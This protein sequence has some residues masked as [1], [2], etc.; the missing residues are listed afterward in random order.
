[1]SLATLTPD[2]VS[3][4]LR[5]HALVQRATRDGIAGRRLAEAER[6]A[7]MAFL[8]STGID[9][10]HEVWLSIEECAASADRP[11]DL[12][13]FSERCETCRGDVPQVVGCATCLGRGRG[14]QNV[15]LMVR[16]PAGLEDE[17]RI[18]LTGMGE[19]GNYGARRGDLYLDIHQLPHERFQREG[20][21]VRSAQTVDASL[22]A[23]G[24]IV[25]VDT[26]TG[27]VRARIPPGTEPGSTLRLRGYGMPWLRG[28]GHGDFYVR[29]L[30]S[31]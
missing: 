7:T 28:G 26:P 8:Q 9:F 27:V 23:K 14:R 24:G 20:D 30:V 19:V 6:K 4:T 13:L 21:D 5:V 25:A 12:T 10:A 2:G 15:T 31:P 3:R 17:L 22:L 18:R 16:F 29:L 1:M 11:V